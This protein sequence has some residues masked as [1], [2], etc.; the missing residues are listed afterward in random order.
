MILANDKTILRH[1][2]EE[3]RAISELPIQSER[4]KLWRQLN[5]LKA[6]RPMVLVSPEGAWAEIAE[7]IPLQCLDP[8]AQEWERHLRNRI[9]QFKEIGDDSVVTADFGVEWCI[10]RG[11]YGLE[12]GVEKSKERGG[13]YKHIAPIKDLDTDLDQLK[14]R[15]PR[16]D[17]ETTQKNF[18]AAQ[19]IFSGLLEVKKVSHPWWTTGL[20]WTAIE[21]IGLENLMIEMYDNPEGLHRLMAFLR[22]DM[23]NY[24]LSLQNEGVLCS[25]NNNSLIG[26][27]GVGYVSDLPCGTHSTLEPVTLKSIWGLCE[28][29]ETVGVS[30]EMFAEF[31]WPYQKP[32][33]AMLGLTYYG[34]CEPVEDRFKYVSE[35]NNL[36]AI[37]VSPWSNIEKCADLYQNNYVMYRKPNPSLVCV[38]FEEELIRKDIVHNLAVARDLNLAFVLKDTHTICHEP[39]RF[40]RWVNIV[41]EEIG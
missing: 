22:D 2:A 37:S 24:M 9:F 11:N 29:Q 25:N 17:R 28:S 1:L 26:S 39:Q 31:I 20:T 19:D 4:E 38:N 5:D 3:V 35:M 34:C 14:F 10:D 13:A 30:P 15:I 27:G 32:L 21:M 8:Q 23:M 16:V 12:L 40:K 18:D 6:Q 41:R 7:T 36:R 33:M